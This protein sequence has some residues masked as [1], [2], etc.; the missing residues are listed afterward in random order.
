MR[1]DLHGLTEQEAIPVIL[2]AFLSIELGD[3]DEVEIITG[4]GFVL[5]RVLQELAHEEGFSLEA[6]NSGSYIVYQ[7]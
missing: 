2:S 4:N 5:K 1:I 6:V 3:E 7:R